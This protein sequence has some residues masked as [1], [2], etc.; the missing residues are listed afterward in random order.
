MQLL[1]I[2]E[3][4]AIIILASDMKNN[5]QTINESII[6]FDE[7]KEKL[8]AISNALHQAQ[9]GAQQTQTAA[10]L[11]LNNASESQIAA[12][13]ITSVSQTMAENVSD[14]IEVAALLKDE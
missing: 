12:E 1:G 13:H 10:D 7:I 6:I 4:D 2:T 8:N 11:A 3:A 9:I 5:E 14:L